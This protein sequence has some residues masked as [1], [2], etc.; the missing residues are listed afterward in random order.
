MGNQGLGNIIVLNIITWVAVVYIS[1]IGLKNI[2]RYNS[3]IERQ[4]TLRSELADQSTKFAFLKDQLERSNSTEQ[5][6][7]MAKLHLGYAG[8]GEQVF[9]II[10]NTHALNRS[11]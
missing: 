9:V 1:Y 2:F 3:L 5:W 8:E 4:T 10:N 6:E 7:N 11:K